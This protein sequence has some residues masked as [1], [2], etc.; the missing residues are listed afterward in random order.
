M[1]IV[2]VLIIFNIFNRYLLYFIGTINLITPTK[3]QIVIANNLFCCGLILNK[4][5]KKMFEER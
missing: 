2:L 4:K 3:P 1:N 5:E